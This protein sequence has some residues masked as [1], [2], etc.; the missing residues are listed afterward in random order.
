MNKSESP[1]VSSLLVDPFYLND[2]SIYF[3]FI[4]YIKNSEQIEHPLVLLHSLH[5][6]SE[7]MFGITG[8]QLKRESIYLDG[9]KEKISISDFYGQE[10][11]LCSERSTTIHNLMSFCGINAYLIIGKLKFENEEFL[12]SFN[13]FQTQ[14]D[15]TLVLLDPTNPIKALKDKQ[16]V[17]VPAIHI[18]EKNLKIE[19]LSHINFDLQKIAELYNVVL[20]S[21]EPART[22]EFPEN[23]KTLY[24]E[25]EN[26]K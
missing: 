15:K 5:F 4:K 14:K 24:T 6:F 20:H 26:V 7:N 10:A 2:K 8:D 3:E 11:A 21:D 12:H 13:I 16:L 1:I 19:N 18:L 25:I 23:T 17:R 9:N 22:Y